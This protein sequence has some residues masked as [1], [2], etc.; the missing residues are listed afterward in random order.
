MP[1]LVDSSINHRGWSQRSCVFNTD[2]REAW[3]RA[4]YVASFDCWRCCQWE[5]L[6]ISAV[7]T[8][9]MNK[10]DPLISCPLYNSLV[11]ADQLISMPALASVPCEAPAG[12]PNLYS[13]PSTQSWTSDSDLGSFKSIKSASSAFPIQQLILPD[14]GN[15]PGPSEHPHSLSTHPI[16]PDTCLAIDSPRSM[17][18]LTSIS[19]L[20]QSTSPSPPSSPISEYSAYSFKPVAEEPES[21]TNHTKSYE[22]IP[23]ALCGPHR[24]LFKPTIDKSLFEHN[25]PQ[26]LEEYVQARSLPSPSKLIRSTRS[27]AK[28]TT[29]NRQ[30][31]VSSSARR[32]SRYESHAGFPFS[33]ST[34]DSKTNSFETAPSSPLVGSDSSDSFETAPTSPKASEDLDPPIINSSLDP[35]MPANRTIVDKTSRNLQELQSRQTLNRNADA[36]RPTAQR[37]PNIFPMNDSL[38][39]PQLEQSMLV[40]NEAYVSDSSFP[41]RPNSPFSPHIGAQEPPLHEKLVHSVLLTAAMHTAVN[42]AAALYDSVKRDGVLSPSEA[43]ILQVSSS[44]L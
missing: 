26:N 31:T 2:F 16:F 9:M 41:R 43:S 14:T 27:A 35:S 23:G 21:S 20:E 25:H 4:D 22:P 32:S 28:P 3:R 33:D 12:L 39:R 34:S 30:S 11:C 7:I 24:D 15:T 36:H 17:N 29:L 19:R 1:A 5:E 40:H 8:T 38:S 10:Y 18:Q 42:E 37:S 6:A 44:L 13:L